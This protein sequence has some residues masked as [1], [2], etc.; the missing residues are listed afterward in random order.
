MPSKVE[1]LETDLKSVMEDAA[2]LAS[3]AKARDD[4]G[5]FTA[6]EM[7]Q[8]E[9]IKAR[10]IEVKADLEKARNQAGL[11][12][13]MDRI[14]ELI[15]TGK[16]EDGDVITEG[17]VKRFSAKRKPQ[18]SAGSWGEQVTDSDWFKAYIGD[19]NSSNPERFNN[20]RIESP[21]LGLKVNPFTEG[22]ATQ[23]A[24]LLVPEQR[25]LVDMG[26]FMRQLVLRDLITVGR[27]SQEAVRYA[28]MTG[29][30]NSAAGVHEAT[31]VTGTNAAGGLK[32]QSDLTVE[33]K[34]SN[35][36]TIAHWFA[37]SKQALADIPA[38]QTYIDQFGRY[39]LQEEEED[40]IIS[41]A[42]AGSSQLEGFR[43]DAGIDTQTFS[44][45][46]FQSIRKAIT[47]LIY[48]DHS[49]PNGVLLNPADDETIDLYR[50]DQGGGANTGSWVGNGPF[51]MGPK[52]LWGLPRVVSEAVP[53]GKAYVADF[54]TIV[55]L[56]REDPNMRMTDSHA[57]YFVRNLVAL[58][59]EERAVQLIMRPKAICEVAT[60]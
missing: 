37:V 18:T 4:S 46:I 28:R 34:T 24:P 49:R 54:R 48:T 60:A 38:L 58:L 55:L 10:V 57:D 36:A 56:M 41:G 25:G 26:I 7:E 17:D 11:L 44:T 51:Q 40:Q 6:E 8:A 59:F 31:T 27:T 42:G 1:E 30:T 3:E 13:E 20:V 14:G 35:V 21:T 9:K 12:Q 52:T 33:T 19:Q 15:G 43:L 2:K 39:G 16:S 53:S 50:L 22:V 32:P 45:N 47:K 5:T 29:F 23:G